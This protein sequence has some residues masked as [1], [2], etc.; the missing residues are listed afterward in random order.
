MKGWAQKTAI[1]ANT[2]S[3]A[4]Q[5]WMSAYNVTVP[6]RVQ[7]RD[8]TAETKKKTELREGNAWIHLLRPDGAEYRV[9]VPKDAVFVE[10]K[11]F[12]HSVRLNM[13]PQ[14]LEVM[15]GSSN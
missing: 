15:R 12:K 3:L 5:G 1:L 13:L 9:Q 2:K 8:L 10:H 7:G 6:C 4:I 14:A 11:W